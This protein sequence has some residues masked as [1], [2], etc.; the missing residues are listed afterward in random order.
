[1]GKSYKHKTQHDLRYS[2]TGVRQMEQ[3]QKTSKC[4][5]RR[6]SLA[7]RAEDSDEVPTAKSFTKYTTNKM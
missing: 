3:T 1:M 7:S 4:D 2:E 5:S 6:G